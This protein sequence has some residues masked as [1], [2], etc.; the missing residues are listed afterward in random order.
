MQRYGISTNGANKF[1]FA[2]IFSAFNFI[3]RR[4]RAQSGRPRSAFWRGV[5]QRSE[6]GG[7]ERPCGTD[8]RWMERGGAAAQSDTPPTERSGANNREGALQSP[9]AASGASEGGAGAQSATGG[10]GERAYA[11]GGTHNDGGGNARQT[12]RQNANIRGRTGR[13]ASKNERPAPASGGERGDPKRAALTR[14]PPLCCARSGREETRSDRLIRERRPKGGAKRVASGRVRIPAG[15][16]EEHREPRRGGASGASA[17]E[18]RE[19]S[20]EASRA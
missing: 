13:E 10:T 9:R 8:A 2:L 6:G 7:A 12:P 16:H 14:M 18:P 5:A 3:K 4:G 17:T 11:R 1:Y 20:R 19:A 15:I